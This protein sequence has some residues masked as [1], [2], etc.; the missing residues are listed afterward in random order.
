MLIGEKLLMLLHRRGMTQTELASRVG[1][2]QA[3][4]S[5]YISG[6]RTPSLAKL[7]NIAA[8][9]GVT[10]DELVESDPAGERG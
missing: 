10:L 3:M 2:S 5:H 1:C 8:V 9:L 7:V 6:T 4:I